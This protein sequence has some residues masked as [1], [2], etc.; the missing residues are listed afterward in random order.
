M[1]KGEKMEFDLRIIRI[2]LNLTTEEFA[3]ELGVTRQ[4]INNWE[5][6]R[7]KPVRAHKLAIGYLVEHKYCD[8]PPE[9]MKLIQMMLEDI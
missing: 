2:L 6:G 4:T 5:R 9:R 7:S 3:K 1:R 8:I